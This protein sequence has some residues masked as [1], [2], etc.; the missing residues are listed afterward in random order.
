MVLAATYCLLVHSEDPE[1]GLPTSATHSETHILGRPPRFE[2]PDIPDINR[3]FYH[4]ALQLFPAR[5]TD[6]FPTGP[7]PDGRISNWIPVPEQYK[8]KVCEKVSI[9]DCMPASAAQKYTALMYK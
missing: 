4:L 7:I 2:I 8:M 1:A 6:T 5:V 9:T 3:I